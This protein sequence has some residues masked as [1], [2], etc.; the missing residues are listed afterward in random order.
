MIERIAQSLAAIV[1]PE[2]IEIRGEWSRSTRRTYRGAAQAGS[3]AGPF[4][5]VVDLR[6]NGSVACAQPVAG[7]AFLHARPA[8]H[9]VKSAPASAKLSIEFGLHTYLDYLPGRATFS[10]GFGRAWLPGVAVGCGPDPV[11]ACALGDARTATGRAHM[12]AEIDRHAFVVVLI[13]GALLK[14]GRNR[15]W[16]LRDELAVDLPADVR[17]LLTRGRSGSLGD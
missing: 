3:G 11:A 13:Q 14:T 4:A 9:W 15:L 16:R 1:P 7:I 8:L 2:P 6:W 12:V 5:E 17:E 10:A